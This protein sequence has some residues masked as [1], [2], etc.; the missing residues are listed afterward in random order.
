MSLSGRKPTVV[1]IREDTK[2]FTSTSSLLNSDSNYISVEQMW[3]SVLGHLT[4][5]MD[6]HISTKM[7][8]AKLR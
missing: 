8:S 7:F 5:M 4:L 6:K 1:A 3:Q 2:S